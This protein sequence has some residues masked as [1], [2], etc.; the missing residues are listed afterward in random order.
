MSREERNVLQ[1][2]THLSP[3]LISLFVIKM[4]LMAIL[5]WRFTSSLP[6]FI[7]N[8]ILRIEDCWIVREI[9][10]PD[11]LVQDSFHFLQKY[12]SVATDLTRLVLQFT[13]LKH[14]PCS[15]TTIRSSSIIR[16]IT[17]HNTQLS[18][19]WMTIRTKFLAVALTLKEK[20]EEKRRRNHGK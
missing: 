14:L 19:H 10:S 5:V 12:Q 20:E 15:P 7:F 8:V 17:R 18:S 16:I 3:E 9:C 13:L 1:P 11:R 6:S 4:P 2:T